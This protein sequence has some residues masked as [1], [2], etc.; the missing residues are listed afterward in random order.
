VTLVLWALLVFLTGVFLGAFEP[1]PEGPPAKRR[2]AKGVGVLACL[3]GAMML[4]GATLGGSDPLKPL[5]QGAMAAAGRSDAAAPELEFQPVESVAELE[6]LLAGARADG[7]P[8]MID[9]TADWCVSCR[10]MEAYTFPDAGVIAALEPFVLLRADVTENDDDD[11]ALLQYFKSFGPPTI[12]FFD[13]GGRAQESYKLV[14]Y[15]PAEE[16]SAHVTSLAAL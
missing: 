16:F 2:L 11:Q 9:F 6:S 12:A 14:G 7:R 1:L 4:I 10:E 8:V 13:A 15:V 5:P 3:Y